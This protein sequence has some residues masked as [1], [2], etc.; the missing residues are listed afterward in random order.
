M[1]GWQCFQMFEFIIYIISFY[2]ILWRGLFQY[3][4]AN[5]DMY[6]RVV[7]SH[8][9]ALFVHYESVMYINVLICAPLDNPSHSFTTVS[10]MG[11]FR[12]F[13]NSRSTSMMFNFVTYSGKAI[14]ETTMSVRH[15]TRFR[16]VSFC[17]S[18]SCP[19][20]SFVLRACAITLCLLSKAG[21]NISRNS[22]LINGERFVIWT[23]LVNK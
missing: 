9:G 1:F 6:S 10:S 21:V 8:P 16:F 23:D 15:S 13:R 5:G 20:L 4:P 22:P 18:K 7:I 2:R 19:L 3:F 14:S 12:H 17:D 11:T